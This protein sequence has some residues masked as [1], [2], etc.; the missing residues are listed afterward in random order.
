MRIYQTKNTHKTPGPL[1]LLLQKLNW[2]HV[3]RVL[4]SILAKKVYSTKQTMYPKA[5]KP[6]ESK[7]QNLRVK[8]KNSGIK[9]NFLKSCQTRKIHMNQRSKHLERQELNCSVHMVL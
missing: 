5:V 7:G 3:H 4:Q 8:T 6:G 9:T 2:T 1:K